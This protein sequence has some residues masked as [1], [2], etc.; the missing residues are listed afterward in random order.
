MFDNFLR[1]VEES[2]LLY[3]KLE[4]KFTTSTY[5]DLAR[6]LRKAQNTYHE[7]EKMPHLHRGNE[8]EIEKVYR[9]FLT[10]NDKKRLILKKHTKG[11][12]DLFS[13]RARLDAVSNVITLLKE[14]GH[15]PR[16]L[17]T[18]NGRPNNPIEDYNIAVRMSDETALDLFQIE[19]V[20]E[21]RSPSVTYK[22]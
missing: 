17:R 5:M 6:S 4:S 9:R 1:L 21:V 22:Y 13:I 18:K 14:T 16:S 10:L 2:D 7:I 3:R 12:Q 20:Q 11:N 8:P 15:E 19:G